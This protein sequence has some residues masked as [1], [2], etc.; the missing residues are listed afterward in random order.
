MPKLLGEFLQE[1]QEPFALDIYLFER[2][3]RNHRAR[4]FKKWDSVPNC[5]EFAKAAFGRLILQN[6]FHK[7]KIK[8][9]FPGNRNGQEDKLG[10]KQNKFR[11]ASH[12]LFLEAK[13]AYANGNTKHESE[14]ESD[15][16]ANYD[17]N[18]KTRCEDESSASKSKPKRPMYSVVGPNSYEQYIINKRALHETKRLL[19]DCL[20]EVI[21]NHRKIFEKKGRHQNEQQLKR[22]LGTEELWQLVCENVWLWSK[23]SIHETNTLVLLN[24][25][26]L[27]SEEE[28]TSL[29][30]LQKEEI[31]MEIGEAI[32]EG[33]ISELF[34]PSF[35]PK[36]FT[37]KRGTKT[38]VSFTLN[39]V[40]SLFFLDAFSWLIDL[41]NWGSRK[42]ME[43]A[44]QNKLFVGGISWET[45]ED[46][47]NEHFN[48]YGVVS[49]S[50][51]A[52][53]RLSGQPRGFAFV[54][55]SELSAVDRA[56]QDS[57]QILNRTVGLLFILLVLPPVF[58]CLCV[59]V[60][61]LVVGESGVAAEWCLDLGLL[62]MCGVPVFFPCLFVEV[63]RAIP[64]REQQSQQQ[65]NR[66]VSRDF[67]RTNNNQSTDEFRTKKIFVGGL[68]TNLTEDEFRSYFAKFGRITDVVV[69][70]DNLTHRPRGFGFITFV[71]E[72]S[73]EEVMQK[74]FHE[75]AGKLV[76]VKRAV[77]KEGSNSNGN[78]YSGRFDN[79]RGSNFNSYQSGD[80]IMPYNPR[81]GYFPAGYTYGPGMFGGVYP[82][83]GYNGIGYGLS[84]VGPR[85]PW[86][87]AMVRGSFLPF[88]SPTPVFPGYINGGPSVMGIAPNRH[89]VLL[90]TG[91]SGKP[92]Q[93]GF[94]DGQ[95]VAQSSPSSSGVNNLGSNHFGVGKGL[96]AGV[97]RQQGKRGNDKPYRA[98]NSS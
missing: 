14:T 27:D 12:S 15:D 97:S 40:V 75:L 91:L 73:V 34:P 66:G 96:G 88:A 68:S 45:T 37:S 89:G 19:I 26:F 28:W 5:V 65:H 17:F 55:F 60:C 16:K 32:L 92:G 53:D 13:T 70:H 42:E 50:V 46:I 30:E 82:S 22:I 54:T 47:L 80:Y 10:T 86:A 18:T 49:G 48:K 78:G 43:D 95:H 29:F 7:A 79:S 33:I 41:S 35:P 63:K 39:F 77:P 51:V 1:Q 94:G 62:N 52:K 24:Y 90:G 9:Y 21:E 83:S 20:R 74:N 58:F 98:T 81:F 67:S 61:F 71:S 72:D 3:F 11:S 93:M 6:R 59:F 2:G 31:A 85:S 4:S 57:H 23:N 69:M 87:P 44:E 25:D 38:L 64:R 36:H 8:S 56:L 76:E 84:L